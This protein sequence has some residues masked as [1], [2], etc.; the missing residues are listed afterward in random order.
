[1]K[2]SKSYSFLPTIV[3]NNIKRKQIKPITKLFVTTS[4]DLGF[5]NKQIEK[6]EEIVKKDKENERKAWDKHIL[7]NIY[8]SSGK[9][10]YQALKEFSHR[11]KIKKNYDISKIDWTKQ[12]YLN[13]KQVKQILTGN[14]ISKIIL[15]SVEISKRLKDKKIYLHDFIFQTKN[16][17]LKNL[18]LKLIKNERENITKK[19]NEYENALNYE[20][21]SLENDIDKF[22][23]YK[24][25]TK[26]QIK[27]DETTLIKLNQ[28]N[29]L[30][31]EESKK[32]ANEYKYIVEEI[33]RYITL[34]INYKT[35]ASFVHKLIGEDTDNININLN[36][37]I[38][39]KKWTEKDLNL[40]IKKALNELSTYLEKI[41][42]NEKMLDVLSD[43]NRLEILFQIME[44][45]ILKV[46]EEKE[47]YEEE[48]KKIMEEN[49][50]IY[51]KLM[52]EYENKK[53]KYDIYLNELKD[54]K[55][56]MKVVD[57]DHELVDY[58]SDMNFLL[59]DICT[60][61]LVVENKKKIKKSMSQTNITSNSNNLETNMEQYE[62]YY[63]KDVNK[64]FETLRDKQFYTQSLINEI[65][66]YKKEDP[67]LIRII[68]SDIRT[69]NRLLK[70][71]KE[72]EKEVQ[73]EDEKREK[74]IKKF[75]Q[76]SIIRK[77]NFREPIPYHIIQERKKHIVKYK[78]ESTSTN[79]LFY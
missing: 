32:L 54:E 50:K 30:L 71:Q 37:Y 20:K 76:N 24:I 25:G 3:S 23:L 12:L 69:S 2:K 16:I 15:E 46:F 40:Y 28:K 7:N 14:K 35:Y 74:F 75:Q 79:L 4:D 56:K 22:D 64:C 45:N 31:Y 19:E 29:K 41:S 48:Q 36:E 13:K 59:E 27:N 60:F 57:I 21:K 72:K 68:T 42:L 34:I 26:Q 51:N 55:K 70:R 61:I 17:S 78:P 43:N 49:M 66:T 52:T 38:N 67:N 44:D 53:F 47:K 10:N 77:Y 6:I 1:M 11:I 73:K 18:K 8:K 33:I 39:Y 62:Y 63:E 58:Y 5:A 65:E 9:S